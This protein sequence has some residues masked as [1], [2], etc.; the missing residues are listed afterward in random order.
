MPTLERKSGCV[1]GLLKKRRIICF[2]CFYKWSINHRR[3]LWGTRCPPK[4]WY[5]I[6][7]SFLVIITNLWKMIAFFKIW[8]FAIIL[9]QNYFFMRYIDEFSLFIAS[10][11]ESFP[12]KSK[13]FYLTMFSII[14][15]MSA[16]KLETTYHSIIRFGVSLFFSP[17][18]V[19]LVLL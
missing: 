1:L 8:I 18:I 17:L 2:I 11:E 3:G 4:K 12:S 5:I 13:K 6:C 16:V 9:F 14:R 7:Q 10:D 19:F 15:L